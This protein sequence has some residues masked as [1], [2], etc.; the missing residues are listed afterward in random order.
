MT[1]EKMTG[2]INLEELEVQAEDITEASGV[3]RSFFTPAF[4]DELLCVF[5]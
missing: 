5:G 2:A 4:Y 1:Y 3:V